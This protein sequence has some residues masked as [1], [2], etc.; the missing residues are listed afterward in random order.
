[1]TLESGKYWVMMFL[2]WSSLSKRLGANMSELER[3]RAGVDIK[4]IWIFPYNRLSFIF[5]CF[6]LCFLH[7]LNF[8]FDASN[9]QA[10]SYLIGES[11][12]LFSGS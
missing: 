6:L 5:L 2:P 3:R 11:F 10:A 8:P 12:Y 7:E 1:M 4:S 9:V